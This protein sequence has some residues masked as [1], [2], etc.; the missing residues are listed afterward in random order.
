MPCATPSRVPSSRA[1]ARGDDRAFATELR[2]AARGRQ[3]HRSL[4]GD[5]VGSAA[6]NE[7]ARLVSG[8]RDSQT[9]EDW[10]ETARGKP[11]YDSARDAEYLQTWLQVEQEV[12]AGLVPV[13][14]VAGGAAIE[15][16]IKQRDPKGPDAKAATEE[17][18]AAAEEELDIL[19]EARA[20]GTQPRIHGSEREG[21]SVHEGRSGKRIGRARD[22]DGATRQAALHLQRLARA[23][24]GEPDA[25]QAPNEKSEVL[26]DGQR[27]GESADSLGNVLG[28][29]YR[30]VPLDQLEDWERRA[31]LAA[32]QD[33][34]RGQV[35]AVRL[36]VE[37]G[38]GTTRAA[39]IAARHLLAVF[40]KK[41]LFVKTAG[42]RQ[43][44]FDA[45]VNQGG[46]NTIVIDADSRQGITCLFDQAPAFEP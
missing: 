43:L 17:L 4:L 22:M 39:R 21:Y 9:W 19:E 31:L 1:A 41:I 20:D 44:P 32:E 6:R 38:P 10:I 36:G 15:A 45:F 42:E 12:A 18:A 16:E 5:L 27:Y 2:G 13:V 3:L 29:T 25:G 11:G 37:D 46:T 30:P 26:P 23:E 33:A 8:G 35:R 40:Q 14:K 34:G 7:T 24:E 28:T